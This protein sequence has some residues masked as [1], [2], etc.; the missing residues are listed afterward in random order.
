MKNLLDDEMNLELLKYLC[1]GIGVEINISELSKSLGKHRNTIKDKINKLIGYK[2][3]DKP[4]YPYQ[5][6]WKEYPLMVVS[7]SEFPRDEKTIQFIENDKQI[8]A[9]FFFK[10]ESYNTLMIE[11]HKDIYSYQ[12][13]R[14]K[15]F[16]KREISL[17]DV[18]YPSEGIYLSM[19]RIVKYDPRTSLKVVEENLKN[20]RQTQ[21]NGYTIDSLSFQILNLL[22]HGKG[23]RTNEN[24]LARKLGVHRRTVQ[25][26]LQALLDEK[27]ISSPACRF[28]RLLVPPEY[29]MVLSFLE[30]RTQKEVILKALREEIHIPMIIIAKVDRYNLFLVSTFYKIEDHLEWQEK[31]DQ[32]FPECIGSVKNTYLSPAMTFSIH[33]QYV[34]VEAIKSKLRSVRGK[35]IAEIVKS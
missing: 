17:G 11:Y 21:I 34:S 16:E 12:M 24:H 14:E 20:Q 18:R 28:P 9:A 10:E 13:W 1:S 26:R 32:R 33:Q 31:F 25:R 23:V 2:I 19:K 22:M 27:I 3:I 35:K 30:I 7:R 8:F 5:G 6:L 15:N 4:I 29:I